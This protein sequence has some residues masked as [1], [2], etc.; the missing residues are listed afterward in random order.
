MSVFPGFFPGFSSLGTCVLNPV[1]FT[2]TTKT[3]YGKVSSWSWNFGDQTNPGDTSNHAKSILE[4][5]RYRNEKCQFIVAN[6]KGCKDT[7]NADRSHDG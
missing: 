5:Q 6:S 7:V 4:I 3:R 2:D 1:L